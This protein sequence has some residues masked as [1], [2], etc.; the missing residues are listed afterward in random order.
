MALTKVPGTMVSPPQSGSVIQTVQ[1]IATTG[2]SLASTNSSSYVTTGF[3]VTITPQ[4]SNSKILLTV[5]ST[6]YIQGT[7]PIVGAFT[8]YRGGTNIA[9]GGTSPQNLVDVQMVT[10]SSVAG[11]L[12]IVFLD[13]PATTS[14]TTYTVYFASSAANTY[15][16]VSV[17]FAGSN[18]ST[19][20]AQEIAA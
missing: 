20:T 16:G 12:S 17:G 2:G 1:A 11:P 7:A 15:F 18:T 3:S 4:F 14:S 10:G 9:P 5:Q 8:I 13:S 19:F 6:Y